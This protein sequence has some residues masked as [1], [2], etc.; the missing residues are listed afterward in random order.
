MDY[1]EFSSRVRTKHP[2]AY[3]DLNDEALARKVVAKFPD[4][5][6]DVT[7]EGPTQNQPNAADKAVSLIQPGITQPPNGESFLSR[8]GRATGETILAP[9]A[10]LVPSIRKRLFNPN[11][12]QYGLSK[13]LEEEGKRVGAA[14]RGASQNYAEEVPGSLFGQDYPKTAAAIGAGFSTVADVTSDSLT[15]SAMQ[16]SLGAEGVG[17]MGKMAAPAMKAAAVDPARRA[18]GFQKSQL[19]SQ[20]SPFET[21]RKV[22]QANRAAESMLKESAISPT[23]NIDDTIKSATKVLSENSRKMNGVIKAVDEAG[24]RISPIDIDEK[25]VGELNP[26]FVDEKKIVKQIRKDLDAY[27]INGL[28]LK[29]ADELRARWGK[30]GFQDRTVTSTASNLYRKAWSSIDNAIKRH[31]QSVAPDLG[32]EYVAAKAGQENAINALRGLGNKQAAD[33]GNNV[34]SLPTKVLA[35][36]RLAAGDIPGALATAGVTEALKRRGLAPLARGLYGAG[37]TLE[38]GARPGFLTSIS[39]MARNKLGQGKNK[40]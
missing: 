16:Q 6:S 20:K 33:L 1:R 22:A 40:K 35:A 31:I 24:H 2:G 3:D 17:I 9:V 28:S 7:F 11:M 26:K 19:V 29:D 36:G 32:A 25:L 21:A 5:Y 14:V 39:A 27:D 12:G 4:A 34:L 37:R 13:V 10:P 38:T 23:G 18:L 30:I 15:P 8:L